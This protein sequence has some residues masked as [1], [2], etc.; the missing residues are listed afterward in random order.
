MEVQNQQEKFSYNSKT[1]PLHVSIAGLEQ[2]TEAA[3]TDTE[4]TEPEGHPPR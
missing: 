3:L 1:P 4:G 2:P